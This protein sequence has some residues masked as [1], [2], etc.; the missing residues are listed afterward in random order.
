MTDEAPF[1]IIS[2]ADGA[3]RHLSVAI[4]MFFERKDLVPIH[5]LAA[6]ALEVLQDL[7]KTK[8]IKPIFDDMILPEKKK[9][10]YQ[11]FRQPQNF[12][13]HADRDG[14]ENLKFYYEGTKFFIIEALILYNLLGIALFPEAI[15][16]FAWFSKKHPNFIKQGPLREAVAKLRSV[17]EVD[18]FHSVLL[19]L[20]AAPQQFSKDKVQP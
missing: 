15:M 18:D 20:D 1:E 4:R 3:K 14:D 8:G 6:A 19:A 13:K 9:E 17:L 7:C 11:I 12:F 10:L 2:K 5:T 16:F